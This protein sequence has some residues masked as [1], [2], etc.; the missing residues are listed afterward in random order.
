MFDVQNRI[1][2]SNCEAS[3]KLAEQQIGKIPSWWVSKMAQYQRMRS[4]RERKEKKKILKHFSYINFICGLCCR[5]HCSHGHSADHLSH[6]AG[7]Q[8][9][10]APSAASLGVVGSSSILDPL[11]DQSGQF[12]PLVSWF[13]HHFFSCQRLLV[14]WDLVSGQQTFSASR[15]AKAL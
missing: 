4:L 13:G 1:T 9:Y 8:H 14:A 2:Y 10:P 5:K 15:P 3:C 6:Q 11:R 12:H 7:G